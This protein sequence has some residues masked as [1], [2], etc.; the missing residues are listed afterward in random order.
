MVAVRRRD[1]IRVVAAGGLRQRVSAHPQ[2][3]AFG[4]PGLLAGAGESG[5]LGGAKTG[6]AEASAA[7]DAAGDWL[8][9]A[10]AI[11]ITRAVSAQPP[12]INNFVL[13]FALITSLLLGLALLAPVDC[14][15][16]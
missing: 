7:L 16:S 13:D 8:I 14:R 12:P 2:G 4:V 1:G 9:R 3:R 15:L 10:T 11:P 5:E 6:A